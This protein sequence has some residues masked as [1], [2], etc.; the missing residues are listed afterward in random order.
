MSNHKN[1]LK[2]IECARYLKQKL[3]GKCKICGYCKNLSALDFHHTDPNQKDGAIGSMINF[4][5]FSTAQEQAKKCILLCKNCHSQHHNPQLEIIVESGKLSFKN[6]QLNTINKECK[7][8]K[9]YSG[10]KLYCS[11]VCA[12]FSRRKVERPSK[13]QL[14]SLIQNNSFCQIG[15]MY[16]VSDNSVRKWAKFYDIK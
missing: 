5:K 11:N 6:E 15:R 2:R 1:N 8:C 13:Q 12:Q 7:T 9:K 3:G 14:I 16:N 4:F 10:G